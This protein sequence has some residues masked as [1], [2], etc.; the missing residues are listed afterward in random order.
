MPVALIFAQYTG[1]AQQPEFV[2][3]V[4][5]IASIAP[6]QI[7]L[8]EVFAPRVVR[9]RQG[10]YLKQVL[11]VGVGT[12]I[13][14]T[15]AAYR[16]GLSVGSMVFVCI[17]AQ[18]YIWC[19]YAAAQKILQYQADAV[20]GGR[21]SYIVG[22]IIPLT[23]LSATI[24]YWIGR[25]VGFYQGGFL[26]LLILLPNLIQ[27]VCI[28]WLVIPQAPS[29]AN[30]TVIRH[31]E[32]NLWIGFFPMAIFMA[33]VA[34]HWK[35]E[36]VESA[37]GFAALSVYLI[38]PFSSAWLI[39]SKSQYLTREK[40]GGPSLIFW[41]LPFLVGLTLLLNVDSFPWVFALALISQV[42]TFKFIT[43]VRI[44]AS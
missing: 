33:V 31:S 7:Y 42:L 3:S 2:A 18:S 29:L 6:I 36:L 22:S 12:L 37:E 13:L 26:Y 1:I 30:H 25:K 8:N 17:C 5:V 44:K 9:Y 41:I 34:Q 11:L 20:F 39:F 14:S 35:V 38:S 32:K 10:I 24:L 28:R 16:M 43:D 21:Y 19:S 4:L 40:L 23:F 15:W 27:Y